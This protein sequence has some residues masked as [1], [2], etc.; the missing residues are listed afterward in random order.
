MLQQF[1]AFPALLDARD[2]D[3]LK[4]AVRALWAGMNA[5]G[6]DRYQELLDE[7]RREFPVLKQNTD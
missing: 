6:H 3:P 2:P 1:M 5:F 4:A 7:V